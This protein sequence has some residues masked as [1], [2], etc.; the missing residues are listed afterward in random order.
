MLLH[1]RGNAS[2]LPWLTLN[3]TSKG[4]KHRALNK[5]TPTQIPQKKKINS[6]SS[7]TLSHTCMCTICIHIVHSSLDEMNPAGRADNTFA[8]L[9]RGER[10]NTVRLLNVKAGIDRKGKCT[11]ASFTQATRAGE[12][13][14]AP[15]ASQR[16]RGVKINLSHEL[17]ELFLCC[18]WIHC[19]DSVCS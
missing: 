17:C 9:S 5:Y 4:M 2:A 19:G 18:S 7:C 6:L 10:L 8:S 13:F 1:F 11:V 16:W 3:K 14:V 15:E 12:P